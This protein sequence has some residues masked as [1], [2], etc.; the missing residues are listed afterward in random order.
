MANR[1]YLFVTDHE[2]ICPDWADVPDIA[3]QVLAEDVCGVPL[4]WLAMFRPGDLVTA[5]FPAD[6]DDEED[7]TVTAPLAP[8]QRALDQ[9]D[10]ALPVLARVFAD[11]GPL[12]GHAALLRAGVAAMP[13]AFVTVN[14]YEIAVLDDERAWYDNLRAGLAGLDRPGGPQADRRCLADLAQLRPG[15][16]FPPARLLLDQLDATDDD[17]WN[18]TR[19][20]GSGFGRPA[21]WE[22]RDATPQGA[23]APA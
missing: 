23:P 3:R 11:E 1:C 19:L 4:L 14:P 20:L 17:W 8:K 6:F 18:H 5:T 7:V 12:D 21:P 15:R 10:A 22:Q 2:G 16:P 13:G 9:L